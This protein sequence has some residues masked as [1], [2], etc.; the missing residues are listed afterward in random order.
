ML[1]Q[2]HCNANI[3]SATE[4]NLHK[5]QYQRKSGGTIFAI[6]QKMGFP[7]DAHAYHS[8]VDEIGPGDYE[9]CGKVLRVKEIK[10]VRDGKIEYYQCGHSRFIP[11]KSFGKVRNNKHWDRLLGFQKNAVEL[12]E[13]SD[14]NCMLDYE[15]GLGKTVIAASVLRENYKECGNTLVVGQP[16]DKYRLQSEFIEWACI[17][18]MLD[19]PKHSMY[20][21]PIVWDGKTPL[22]GFKNVITTWS[23]LTQPKFF[24]FLEL[25]Q[26]HTLIVDE[27]H[28]YKD[29]RSQRTKAMMQLCAMPSVKKKIFMS[30]TPVMNR[31]MDFFPVLNA[32]KPREFPDRGT[33][34]SRCVISNEGKVLGL[35]PR[36]RD[37]YNNITEDI[38]FRMDKEKA[39]IPFPPFERRTK[40]ITLEDCQQ[41][42][43]N[44]FIKEYNA[45]CDELENLLA[46]KQ[47]RARAARSI[48]GLMQT[49]RHWTGLIKLP[50]IIRLAVDY[51]EIYREKV[52]I[53]VHHKLVRDTLVKALQDYGVL[54]MSDEDAEE[55]D[56]IEKV[57]KDDPTK[58]VLVASIKGAGQGRNLQ[59]CKNAMVMER[60]W[61][62]AIENQFDKRFHRIKTDA[63]GK[64][65]DH[66]TENDKVTV[67][68]VCLRN[69]F[70]EFTDSMVELKQDICASEEDDIDPNNMIALASKVA[71]NR[72]KFVGI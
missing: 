58:L 41:P 13:E 11:K 32:L 20:H 39:N 15:M 17:E 29:M 44:N 62:F 31:I 7:D 12:V 43:L 19:D 22:G 51:L 10:K 23:A 45:I 42:E 21:T 1:V 38:V 54:S 60:W 2:Q 4:L 28:L 68:Y 52:T 6:H 35:S 33:L 40:W 27:C 67:E 59:F 46:D 37:W 24:K 66:F 56:R 16:M 8:R 49:I 50:A 9:P 48:I 72:L 65:I 70:D 69:S 63:N 5:S 26:P 71:A 14:V 53:G 57:F 64:V 47:D 61:N 3:W 36:Y 34:N 55:K 30:G 18:K 25:W